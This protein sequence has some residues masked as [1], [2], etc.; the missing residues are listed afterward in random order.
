M[1]I[2]DISNEA[3]DTSLNTSKRRLTDNQNENISKRTKVD[4]KILD[5]KFYT[6][7]LRNGDKVQAICNLCGSV[8]S[9]S[10]NGTGN[11]TRHINDKH[12]ER[13]PEMYEYLA[14]RTM[15]NVNANGKLTQSKLRSTPVISSDKVLHLIFI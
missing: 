15:V 12:S 1:E 10:I 2:T 4:P 7:K 3:N 13:A 5:G 14:S 8:R 9:G 11:F 6:I